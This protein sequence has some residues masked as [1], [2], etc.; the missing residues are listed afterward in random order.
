[1]IDL[2]CGDGRI[3]IRAS[4]RYNCMAWGCEIEENLV[5]KFNRNIKS[6][7]LNSRVFSIIGDLCEID[8]SMYSVIVIYLLPEA[9]ELIK[10]KLHD[11]LAASDGTVL[12][13]NTWGPKDWTPIER[14]NCG[15]FKNVS[16][17][18]YDKTSLPPL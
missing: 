17:I 1:M 10:R 15:R 8:Y 7:R 12:V 2:G 3:C 5:E 6:L 14:I 18:K 9:I 11:T 13:C 16:L 4:L